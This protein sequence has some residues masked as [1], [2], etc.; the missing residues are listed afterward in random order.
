MYKRNLL[1]TMYRTLDYPCA[2]VRCYC[3]MSKVGLSAIQGQVPKQNPQYKQ[4]SQTMYMN[5]KHQLRMCYVYNKHVLFF[6]RSSIKYVFWITRFPQL[7][8][9][10]RTHTADNRQ[11]SPC[12]HVRS[13]HKHSHAAY[14]IAGVAMIRCHNTGSTTFVTHISLCVTCIDA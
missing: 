13:S 1:C 5:N 14:V 6:V 10:P 9:H 12:I 2:V 4:K 7:S 11:T 8:V 3:L